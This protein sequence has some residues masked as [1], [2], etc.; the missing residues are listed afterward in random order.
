[1]DRQRFIFINSFRMLMVW[2]LLFCAFSS[3]AQSNFTATGTVVDET[4]EPMIG[5]TVYHIKGTSTTSTSTNNKGNFKINV[6]SDQDSLIFSFVG[7]QTQTVLAKNAGLITMFPD[8]KLLNEVVVT[9]IYE[10]KA[11]SYTG[12]ATTINASEIQRMSNQNVFQSLKNLAPSLYIK[13]N[14]LLGSNPNAIPTMQMRGVSSFPAEGLS[15]NIKGNYLK[16]PNQ[17]LILLDGFETTAEYILDLDMNRIES[18]T[19]L[20]D[21]AAKALYGSKAA[22]GVMVIETKRLAGNELIATY[23]G[24]LSIE[25]PDLT[26]YDLCN[27]LEKLQVEKAEGLYYNMDPKYQVIL[28]QVYNTRLEMALRG[29]N[30]YW[31]SKPLQLGV[32]HKHTLTV[33]VGD[34]KTLRNMFT[35]SYNKIDGTMIGNYRETVSGSVSSSYRYK[36]LLFRNNM[37]ITANNSHESPY[38]KF[39]DYVK[40]NPYWQAEDA[41]G[42]VLRW[43]EQF[44][45]T[46]NNTKIPNPMYDALIGTVNKGS[47]TSLLDNFYIEWRPVEGL[48]AMARFSYSTKRSD[49]DEFYPATHSKFAN[50]MSDPLRRGQ[51]FLDNGKSNAVSGDLSANY[52]KTIDKNHLL[53]TVDFVISENN[54]AAYHFETEG[55]PNNNIADITF[56]RQYV[57]GT[58]PVGLSS[59]N[60]E[61]S[62][63]GMFSYDYDNR[64]LVDL[65]FREGASSL[66][67]KDSRWAASW[68]TGIGWNIH[69]ETFLKDSK[70]L[71]RLKLRASMGLTGNQNFNTS[72]AIGT[73]NYYIDQLYDY[74][75]GA[76]LSQLA[77]PFLKWEQKMDY[78]VGFDF[79]STPLSLTFD[80]FT[81]DSKNMLTSISI[82]TS[83]GFSSVY[84]NL[85]KVRNSGFEVNMRVKAIQTKNAFLSLNVMANH[86]K[87]YIVSLS[88]VMREENKRKEALAADRGNPVPVKLYKDGQALNTIWAVPSAGIDPT[89]GQEVY[90][91][92][93]GSL[94]YVYNPA[95]LVAAGNED[96]KLY[97]T[98]GFDGEYKGLGISVSM[99]YLLGADLYNS[100]LVDR[101]EN[102]DPTYN[103]DRRVLTGRWQVPGQIAQFKKLGT[104]QYDGDPVA[105]DE[106]TR[107]TTRFVQKRS[108][109]DFASVSLYYEFPSA[110]IK[111]IGIKRLRLQGYLLNAYKFSTIN[112]ERGLTTPFSRTISFSLTATF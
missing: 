81:A 86:Y 27:A 47:Y 16:D 66:Y 62:A 73:Y 85:G 40:M 91:K 34:A 51:Y 78:D 43:A 104:F 29:L 1:M 19:L 10:R 39:S 32:G 94:T 44:G 55:F 93:D 92:Q 5:V 96:P 56:A 57:E 76:Y 52:Q 103:V 60:R 74:Q 21:A 26:S 25:A 8:L 35:F 109:L 75:T 45:Q 71:K 6:S 12:S 83:T 53:G 2:V 14:L 22:N 107:A 24:S 30:T 108:E 110:F 79:E 105:Y 68:S 38:G 41:S 17:P 46:I 28:D 9:G 77:N 88:D 23:N 69:N 36:N 20:K 59:L 99:Y 54:Y 61:I 7:Y 48:T 112:I 33:E 100:T 70:W 82:P 101:V 89:T 84:D 67:G 90:I 4:G 111:H 50:F 3:F 87:N 80:Y 11:E 58:R 98:F 15:V 13:D 95:D 102:I 18:V 49:A 31:L 97:G 42:N 106:K 65:T 63:L 64:Y 37:T 72:A